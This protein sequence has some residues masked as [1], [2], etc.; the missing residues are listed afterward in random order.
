[1]VYKAKGFEV[2]CLDNI[3]IEVQEEEFVTFIG[4]SGCG[5][6]TLLKL[7]AGLLQP[8]KG[9][10]WMNSQRVTEPTGRIGFVFQNP[11]LLNWRTVL[12][13]VLL[14][15]EILGEDREKYRGKAMDLLELTGLKG[16]EHRYPRELSGGMQQRVSICRAL[17][18]DPEIL[19]MDEPFGALDAITREQMNLELTR[20]WQTQK[21]TVLFVTHSIPEA[22]FLSDRVVVMS[23]RPAHIVEDVKVNLP[24]P[25]AM[26][27]PR[28]LR[29]VDRVRGLLGLTKPEEA[30]SALGE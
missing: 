28:F 29:Y 14:P 13:N 25:R 1:M 6:S 19:L 27:S 2:Y 4:P 9:E 20:I 26:S 5:K 18:T 3:S 7:V 12:E 22:V 15:I 10:I 30:R 24:R 21:K 17:I 16:F 11:V 8:T 23:H